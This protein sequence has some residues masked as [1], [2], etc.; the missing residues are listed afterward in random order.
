MFVFRDTVATGASGPD[1]SKPT[2]KAIFGTIRVPL[3]MNW[4]LDGT[5]LI[6][7]DAIMALK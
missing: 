5:V 3:K 6:F 4:I 1:S 7:S 2:I